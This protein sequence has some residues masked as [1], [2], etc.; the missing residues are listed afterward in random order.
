MATEAENKSN[1]WKKI[2]HEIYTKR[3]QAIDR[4]RMNKKEALAW[5]RDKLHLAFKKLKTGLEEESGIENVSHSADGTSLE[6]T[7]KFTFGE[8]EFGK[9]SLGYS[10]NLLISSKAAL[11]KN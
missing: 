1:N 4:K 10:I 7:L 2:L 8:Y 5:V 3:R 11:S 6:N 9:T